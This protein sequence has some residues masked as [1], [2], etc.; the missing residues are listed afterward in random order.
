MGQDSR[1]IFTGGQTLAGEL[2]EPRTGGLPTGSGD[3]ISRNNR[4]L[5][6]KSK[7]N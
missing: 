6:D 2:L 7:T 5:I 3:K 4:W 1:V